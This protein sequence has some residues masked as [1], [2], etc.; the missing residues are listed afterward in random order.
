VKRGP[1]AAVT[2]RK[3]APRVP[4]KKLAPKR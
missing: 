2:Y 1:K 4:G 3:P